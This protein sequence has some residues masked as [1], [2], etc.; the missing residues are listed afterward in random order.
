[1]T[2]ELLPLIDF[3]KVKK[4]K[5]QF[6]PPTETTEDNKED[7]LDDV[8]LSKHKPKKDK[9]KK[10]KQKEEGKENTEKQSDVPKEGEKKSDE[11][12]IKIIEGYTYDFL[13]ER[14]YKLIN[15]SHPDI[16]ITGTSIKFPKPNIVAQTKSKGCWTNFG[17][18]AKILNRPYDHLFQFILGELGIEGTLGGDNQQANLKAKITQ[19]TQTMIQNTLTKY[20]NDYVRCPNCKSIK[21]E[22]KKD[23][24]TRLMQ[25][26]CQNCKSQRTVQV[27]KTRVKMKK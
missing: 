24:S 15:E 27:L 7:D 6:L 4:K 5:R 10:D 12:K 1:M 21:T 8:V 2:S 20:V 22:I 11:N 23:Q 26:F 3:T 19:S 25:I 9:K 14:I 16:N 17:D 18:F 13:L